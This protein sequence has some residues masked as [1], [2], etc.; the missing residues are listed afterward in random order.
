MLI[1]FSF[2]QIGHSLL[3]RWRRTVIRHLLRCRP[4][5][6]EINNLKVDWSRCT[7]CVLN[8]TLGALRTAT[9]F[10]TQVKVKHCLF[11]PFTE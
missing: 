6:N 1:L 8:D 7:H 5:R 9:S 11:T 10:Y 2:N 3:G 4:C